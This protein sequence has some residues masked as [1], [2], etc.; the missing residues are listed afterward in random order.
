ME[1][2]PG[3]VKYEEELEALILQRNGRFQDLIKYYY[4]FFTFKY[5]I[6][7]ENIFETGGCV[8]FIYILYISSVIC[9]TTGPQPLP[10][11]FLHLMRSRASSFKSS[12][13]PKHLTYM[14]SQFLERDYPGKVIMW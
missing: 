6:R 7:K 1:L 13:V 14:V 11:R 5:F 3:C 2:L 12:P 9:H 8:T 4:F 10:K